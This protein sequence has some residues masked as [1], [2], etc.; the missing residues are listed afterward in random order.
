MGS[1]QELDHPQ[2]LAPVTKLARTVHDVAGIASSVDQAFTVAGSSHRGPTFLDVPMDQFF[3]KASVERPV[4]GGRR[5][6]E[7]DAEAVA[8][9]GDLLA[10]ARRLLLV[11]GTDVWA[12]GA[13]EAALR[14]VESLG[15]PAVTNGMGRGVVPGGHPLLVTK[16]RS[17][18]FGTADL[19]VGTPLTSGSGTASSAART[20][21]RR[22]GSCT[23]RRARSRGTPTSPARR[24]AT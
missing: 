7:P 12:D 24:T 5:R 3:D 1:L 20:A 18:A 15:L 21:P 13:E 10:Q 11:L 23:S 8:E 14:L 16:A 2:V 17:A 4:V 9:I 22:H 19:V 6:V